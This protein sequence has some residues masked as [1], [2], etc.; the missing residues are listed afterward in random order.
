MIIHMIFLS[1]SHFQNPNLRGKQ[2][3][4]LIIQEKWL[5]ISMNISKNL[6]NFDELKYNTATEAIGRSMVLG[7]TTATEIN[8]NKFI[9]E[10]KNVRY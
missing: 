3:R 7:E 10:Q 6:V 4:V 1:H 5:I 2:V 9:E 8:T